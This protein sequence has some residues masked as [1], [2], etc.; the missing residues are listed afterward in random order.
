MT[1]QFVNKYVIVLGHGGLGGTAYEVHAK[2]EDL[3]VLSDALR[4]KVQ[5]YN[6]GNLPI[7]SVMKDAGLE[8]RENDPLPI[9]SEYVTL[10][11]QKTDRTVLRFCVEK[12]LAEH[13]I[14][15]TQSADIGSISSILSK[16]AWY[17]LFPI[18]G[19]VASVW[20]FGKFILGLLV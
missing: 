10:S 6:S 17:C 16:F 2:A 7:L 5:Q 13:H 11:Q 14:M 20:A 12:S 8:F 18:V 19:V 4:D 15:K 1:E 3:L 9:H